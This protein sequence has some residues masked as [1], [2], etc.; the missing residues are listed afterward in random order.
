MSR[1]YRENVFET[2]QVEGQ[3]DATLEGA[4]TG[5][6][7]FEDAFGDQP[8]DRL[9][10]Y[11]MRSAL[12]DADGNPVDGDWEEGI[13]PHDGTTLKRSE[14]VF[15]RSSNSN[16][17]VDW[18]P[19]DKNVWCEAVAEHLNE[20]ARGVPCSTAGGSANSIT[21]SPNFPV[22]EREAGLFLFFT[23]ASDNTAAVQANPSGIGLVDVELHGRALVKGDIRGGFSYALADDGSGPYRLIQLEAVTDLPG[24]V[25][26]TGVCK[27]PQLTGDVDNYSPVD[28][29]T[30]VTFDQ[31]HTILLSS[32]ADGRKIT[33]QAGGRPGRQL[34]YIN[35]GA[36]SVVL[37]AGS[38]SSLAANRYG[39]AADLTLPAKAALDLEYDGENS[40]WMP[41]LIPA[42]A[43]PMVRRAQCVIGGPSD[44][45]GA[46]N[47]GGSTGSAAVSVT[48][49]LTYAAA[50]GF[51]ANGEV[52][53]V[54]QSTNP[55]WTG[56][57]TNGTMYL[58][59]Q[60]DGAGNIT[61]GADTLAPINQDGGS[62][63][64]TNGQFTHNNVDRISK[65]GNGSTAAQVYRVYV[66]EVTVSGSVVTAIR[67]YAINGRVVVKQ[68]SLAASTAYAL[69]HNVGSA[70]LEIE[71][72]LECTSTDQGFAAGDRLY[73]KASIKGGGDYATVQPQ[74]SADRLTL[75]ASF[76]TVN[77]GVFAIAFHKTS[78][79]FGV[80]LDATKWTFGAEVKRSW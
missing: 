53:I 21:L 70:R 24:Q 75:W 33:G 8:S 68:S 1:I 22:L 13:C 34:A 72:W 25:A 11:K 67:W 40:L 28:S 47:F 41:K 73:A 37:P 30:G 64:T 38:A 78:P 7:T 45:N 44:S 2:T 12:T 46:P 58:W 52:N 17:L 54:W 76:G 39:M 32:D 31:I 19:G 6:V 5:A 79:G 48:G 57:S 74:V 14:A 71:H 80:A 42:S 69:N 63:S 65:V 43:T 56:L 36:H 61:R 55:G 10:A 15:I 29:V 62:Y 18:A 49:T 23:A 20:V 27:A 50:A 59:E 26:F 9:V 51:D 60:N 77:G 35:I 66:G 16:A 4:I 3:I